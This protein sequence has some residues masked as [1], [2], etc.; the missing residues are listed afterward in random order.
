MDESKNYAQ[1]SA[2]EEKCWLGLKSMGSPYFC[3]ETE[4]DAKHVVTAILNLQVFLETH[5]LEPVFEIIKSD[6]TKVSMLA[7]PA[8]LDASLMKEWMQAL[9]QDGV[10]DGKGGTL[11]LCSY[12]KTNLEWSYDAIM[13][14]CSPAR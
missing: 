11:P 7:Q 6:G 2:I 10:P 12:D 14:S 1:V 8:M 13:N 3:L 9:R 5:G 4:S